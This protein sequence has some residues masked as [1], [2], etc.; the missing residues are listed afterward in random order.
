VVAGSHSSVPKAER[1]WAFQR[2]LE[3]FV[4]CGSTPVQAIRAGSC[5][6]A[7]FFRQEDRLGSVEPGKLSG[8]VLVEGDAS[9]DLSALRKV[10]RA[11]LNGAR[12]AGK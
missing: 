9:K 5:D 11:M 3:L 6:N 1:G 8:L 4:E 2:E 7:R 12:G 10:R